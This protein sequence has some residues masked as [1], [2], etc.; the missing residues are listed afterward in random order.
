MAI[1]FPSLPLHTN[2]PSSVPSTPT[3]T[4]APTGSIED[5]AIG[6]ERGISIPPLASHDGSIDQDP[7]E[8]KPKIPNGRMTADD[9]SDGGSKETAMPAQQRAAAAFLVQFDGV[10]PLMKQAR[11]MDAR[12]KRNSELRK[13]GFRGRKP[14]RYPFGMPVMPTSSETELESCLDTDDE[15][16]GHATDSSMPPGLSSS[17]SVA[18]SIASSTETLPIAVSSVQSSPSV[19]A[20][21]E[22]SAAAPAAAAVAAPATEN[23]DDGVVTV[24]E[25]TA[26]RTTS[27]TTTPA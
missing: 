2:M 22:T 4:S 14:R 11:D 6:V 23:K 13:G 9:R 25:G 20:P 18:S 5:W 16:G 15:H 26:P 19:L 21:S 17:H 24:V 7:T 3:K 10:H 12:K 1:P 27:R 8:W